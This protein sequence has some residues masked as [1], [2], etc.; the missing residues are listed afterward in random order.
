MRTSRGRSVAKSSALSSKSVTIVPVRIAQVEPTRSLAYFMAGVHW[1]DALTPP[2]EQHLQRL[3]ISIK[4]FLRPTPADTRSETEQIHPDPAAIREPPAA[5]TPRPLSR[6]S[7]EEE[8]QRQPSVVMKATPADD[9]DLRRGARRLLRPAAAIFVVV[10]LPLVMVAAWM[11]VSRPIP[12]RRHLLLRRLR[13]R[14]PRSW[15]PRLRPRSR[16]PRP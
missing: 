13:P 8:Q 6:K 10:A 12:A 5:A 1:L 7:G 9:A 4:A 15:H 2:L 14:H 3:A 11:F 16:Q